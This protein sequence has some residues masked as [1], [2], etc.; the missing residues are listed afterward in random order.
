MY[1]KNMLPKKILIRIVTVIILI[2][3]NI[4]SSGAYAMDGSTLF[5]S[6]SH[7]QRF[8]TDDPVKEERALKSLRY[9]VPAQFGD[10]IQ[11]RKGKNRRL[12][13]HIQ[14]RHADETAQLNIADIIESIESSYGIS[15][16]C[17]E[18]ASGR[19]DTSYYDKFP[20]TEAKELTAKFYVKE[21]LFTGAEYYK[22]L[23]KRS[24]VKA[25]GVE[26]K[27]LYNK[28]VAAYKRHDS[29]K[30]DTALYLKALA[31]GLDGL[32]A[33]IFSKPLKTIDEKTRAYKNNR[34]ALSKY[35][36]YITQQAAQKGVLLS[37]YPNLKLFSE[38][39]SEEETIDFKKAELQRERLIELLSSTLK[40][41]SLNALLENSL[42]FKL[43]KTSAPAYYEYL[44]GVAETAGI[45][46]DK[47]SY[48]EL[49]AY[50]D[51][52]KLSD[53]VDKIAL[54]DELES[55]V[56]DLRASY[57]T[58]GVQGSFDSYIRY[59]EL[60]TD[61]H[62]LKLSK[63]N[64]NEL[65]ALRKRIDITE[66]ASFINKRN[67]AY[68]I[69]ANPLPPL[70]GGH[71]FEYALDYYEIA[72]DRDTALINNTLR[73]M[74]VS[75][76]NSGI[77]VT[78]GFHTQ[79]IVNILEKL[80]ISYVVI[81][82]KIGSGICDK[83]YQRQ[84]DKRMPPPNAILN[85]INS[86]LVNALSTG[87][88]ADPGY[89]EMVKERF[90]A[91]M[92]IIGK[93][94][95]GKGIYIEKTPSNEEGNKT[96]HDA[97]EDIEN[98]RGKTSASGS[99]DS[100]TGVSKKT[101]KKLFRKGLISMLLWGMLTGSTLFV[102]V[103]KVW[104]GLISITPGAE[105]QNQRLQQ[106][107]PQL[108]DLINSNDV[109]AL[110]GILNDDK[111]SFGIRNIIVRN[112]MDN[113]P[114]MLKDIML[115]FE[116][117]K[118]NMEP[119]SVVHKAVYM[120]IRQFPDKRDLA[121]ILFNPQN[122]AYLRSEIFIFLSDGAYQ[123]IN[124][125]QKNLKNI[126]KEPFSQG[127]DNH[128]LRNLQSFVLTHICK[129][130]SDKISILAEVLE[131]P[132]Y[133]LNARFCAFEK[134]Y[135]GALGL[136]ADKSASDAHDQ[137]I[138]ENTAIIEHILF[139][140]SNTL[141]E[142]GGYVLKD[143]Q[144]YIIDYFVKKE[145]NQSIEHSIKSYTIENHV[146]RMIVKALLKKDAKA[147]ISTLYKY[148][149]DKTIPL[150]IK[151]EIVSSFSDVISMGQQ[152]VI[153]H[154]ICPFIES[155]IKSGSEISPDIKKTGKSI[156]PLLAGEAIEVLLKHSN[157]TSA[158]KT[159]KKCKD[160][161][162]SLLKQ[163]EI[164]LSVKDS[165]AKALV[166]ISEMDILRTLEPHIKECLSI[167]SSNKN[168]FAKILN[169]LEEE[170]AFKSVHTGLRQNNSI[171]HNYEDMKL[172]AKDA[173]LFL[174]ESL[175]MQDKEWRYSLFRIML[176]GKMLESFGGGMN[177]NF[178]TGKN[179]ITRC[180]DVFGEKDAVIV[181]EMTI[182][183]EIGHNILF[184][185]G[186]TFDN[187][188]K[189]SAHEFVADA[190]CYTYLQKRY[191]DK[192]NNEGFMEK[193]YDFDRQT[194]H[195]EAVNKE[196]G[197][198]A[199]EEHQAARAE[200]HWLINALKL[201]KIPLN[202]GV[203]YRVSIE[204][205]LQWRDKDNLIESLAK[206]L[207]KELY[208]RIT[209]HNFII[210][211]SKEYKA[212]VQAIDN[213]KQ[214]LPSEETGKNPSIAPYQEPSSGKVKLVPLKDMLIIFGGWLQALFGRR[215]KSG[216]VRQK[217]TGTGPG[218]AQKP[219]LGTTL[220]SD[221]DSLKASSAGI[222]MEKYINE[223]ELRYARDKH[224]AIPVVFDSDFIRTYYDEGHYGITIMAEHLELIKEKH[225][226]PQEMDRVIVI[227]PVNIF[228]DKAEV[229]DSQQLLDFT[230]A[231]IDH[232]KIHAILGDRGLTDKLLKAFEKDPSYA[233][234]VAAVMALLGYSFDTYTA[235]IKLLHEFIARA[236]VC[237]M[238][239]KKPGI[240]DRN[241]KS[242]QED[243]LYY[244]DHD[245]R[246]EALR[247]ALP[248]L[249]QIGLKKT[250]TGKFQ[251]IK[252]T[253]ISKKSSSSGNKTTQEVKTFSSCQ[254]FYAYIIKYIK[255]QAPDV[256]G[257]GERHYSSASIG[258]P[259]LA[260]FSRD[261]LPLLAKA[262]YKNLIIEHL[263]EDIPKKEFSYVKEH[264]RI[265]P[266]MTPTLYLNSKSIPG[267]ETLVL[268]SVKLGIMLYGCGDQGML[269]KK[270]GLN[271][272]K[273][274]NKNIEKQIKKLRKSNSKFVIFSGFSHSE[275]NSGNIPM[276]TEVN[277]G[278]KIFD[279]IK[280]KYLNI[281][282]VEPNDPLFKLEM[283]TMQHRN[284]YFL[285]QA[286]KDKFKVF[287]YDSAKEHSIYAV[288]PLKEFKE[289]NVKKSSSS[290]VALL[291]SSLPAKLSALSAH[292]INPVNTEEYRY[293]VELSKLANNISAGHPSVYIIERGNIFGDTAQV[294]PK[295]LLDIFVEL[296]DRGKVKTRLILDIS[297]DELSALLKAYNLSGP[298]DT[299]KSSEEV[300]GK[301]AY[302]ETANSRLKRIQALTSTE[303]R[304]IS[305][306]GLKG[307]NIGIIANP[308]ITEKEKTD[309]DAIFQEPVLKERGVKVVKVTLE[310][311]NQA[312]SLPGAFY[313]LIR[314]IQSKDNEY[315]I[316]LPPIATPD[317][318]M[319][320][321]AEYR[322]A[323][324]LI[325]Q[326]A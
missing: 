33:Y 85:F 281:Q 37:S 158:F 38:I 30:Q 218:I 248:H 312:M 169:W 157:D 123:D 177:N 262:E 322:K 93:A 194:E 23:H 166:E 129:K 44:E 301:N 319:K 250:G 3:Y 86:M 142:E 42:N 187:M 49:S 170:R 310:N 276:D 143:F 133:S 116:T 62:K 55:C 14:D 136:S 4:T 233:D 208:K 178:I 65:T 306:L 43:N 41:S 60:S 197:F 6:K 5:D 190:L 29:H 50:I 207:N 137:A 63:K 223:I 125:W 175:P 268:E 320:A 163:G 298:Y 323:L 253:K 304:L 100:K 89:A 150:R 181:L 132:D 231:T 232:E 107:P 203:L 220:I 241:L 146:I 58:N 255:E 249:E 209:F 292:I 282:L 258:E 202:W 94:L 91:D 121:D 224:G 39:I 88:L 26:D 183:H 104:P 9:T 211:I 167:A 74:A 198:T 22:I 227:S 78:G 162:V 238:Y 106:L 294:M 138:K 21:G 240:F 236:I 24:G 164:P 313:R 101:G 17:L 34:S 199:S 247:D 275:I 195:A 118:L 229:L 273:I 270:S 87:G 289:S 103:Q 257:F 48:K 182:A 31:K 97:A 260:S 71:A 205:A 72:L 219:N 79:A 105:I 185:N 305:G 235:K 124:G 92:E 83:I 300:L 126:L 263:F 119:N 20:K 165:S 192:Q 40:K 267:L 264:N 53:R 110:S 141:T 278:K 25:Y 127:K 46:I 239:R 108:E 311:S 80:D 75:G 112:I 81:C 109:E 215:R 299:I 191:P 111:K 210:R 171:P 12:I 244:L 234:S 295:E 277:F 36:S 222:T 309:F 266:E 259:S 28:H 252:I 256:L 84:M 265:N 242:L 272:E 96:M 173:L 70:A 61:L 172:M 64:L 128:S 251:E 99:Q 77:L 130:S 216:Y 303:T 147:G 188:K 286:E 196:N 200:L 11:S 324:K 274:I 13:I 180:R 293:I 287:E 214:P 134:L 154:T 308:V 2:C 156:Y 269:S 120:F 139:V 317:N 145:D 186:F 228:N 212:R 174:K 201:R 98:S 321:I 284:H 135:D 184:A 131:N 10:I 47:A 243:L 261:M 237:K 246:G 159:L 7:A 283:F 213:E 291:A 161:F 76:E 102:P 1:S 115:R 168:I 316:V 140:K 279:A 114:E 69:E 54:F 122:S 325:S 245:P 68:G 176:R 225:N 66:I 16:L 45:P 148:V 280:D 189:M 302:N 290:G 160:E 285:G 67:K 56:K 32:K 95:S 314:A 117:S 315:I 326:S 206:P 254:D 288:Y 151:K 230:H 52:V 18:G 297:K 90:P 221:A 307:T 193:T 144:E 179:Y 155:V 226:L 152:Y 15:L 82:P 204:K 153:S 217:D 271:I 19:L 59:V 73:R 35:T 27:S 149:R 318:I 296:A 51:Y 113:K 57:Y 8:L